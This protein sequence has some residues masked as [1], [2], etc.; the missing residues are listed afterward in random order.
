MKKCPDCNNNLKKI[1][2]LNS[3]WYGVLIY[4]KCKKCKEI[5]V[6]RNGINLSIAAP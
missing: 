6:S 4:Y 1:E 5:F 2:E 3:D